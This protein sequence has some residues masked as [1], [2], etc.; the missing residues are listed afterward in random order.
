MKTSLQPWC[1]AG[2]EPLTSATNCVS[3][4]LSHIG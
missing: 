1:F 3:L 4:P 2:L